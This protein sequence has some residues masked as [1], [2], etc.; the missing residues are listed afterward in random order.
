MNKIV[1]ALLEAKFPTINVEDLLEVVNA[2]PNPTIATEVLCGLYESP[3]VN[4]TKEDSDSE[5]EKELVSYNK[6]ENRVLYSYFKRESRR[7]T[8]LKERTEE[9]TFET[10]D[11]KGYYKSEKAKELG[12]TEE[13]FL[14]LYEEVVVYGKTH[15]NRTQSSMSLEQWNKK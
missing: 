10:K 15:E 12:L 8:V 2:T 5:V 4:K 14:K 13:E 6:Y 3:F 1:K 7:V 9:P 11:I